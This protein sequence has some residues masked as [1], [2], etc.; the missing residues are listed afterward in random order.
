M[1]DYRLAYQCPRI[2][3]CCHLHSNMDDYRRWTEECKCMAIRI[4]IPIWTIIDA[5]L[6]ILSATPEQI[7]IPIWTI[8]DAGTF[9]A[10]GVRNA[11]TFQYGRL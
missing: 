9:G 7:Y 8:I 5:I 3:V 11:F 2:G 1:D 10:S 4:Y 6:G